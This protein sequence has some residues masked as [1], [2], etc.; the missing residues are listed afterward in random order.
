MT[1]GDPESPVNQA[2]FAAKMRTSIFE[3]KRYVKK[4]DSP[5]HRESSTKT[6]SNFKP[7]IRKNPKPIS[8][9]AERRTP[10][11]IL[12]PRGM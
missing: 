3:A 12:M 2:P 7:R 10:M 8:V 5:V 11:N 1:E 4:V 6:P 9:F